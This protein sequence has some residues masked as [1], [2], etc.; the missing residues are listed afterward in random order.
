[1]KTNALKML[2][3]RKHRYAL[4]E[5]IIEIKL[6]LEIQPRRLLTSQIKRK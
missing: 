3:E 4:H 6:L 5:A 1:M 2:E